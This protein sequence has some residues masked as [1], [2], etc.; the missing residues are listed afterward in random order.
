MDVY[1]YRQVNVSIPRRVHDDVRAQVSKSTTYSKLEGIL[2]VE[3]YSV[4]SRTRS[5]MTGTQIPQSQ[6]NEKRFDGETSI[7]TSQN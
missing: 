6:G 4:R 7:W 2:K 3:A 5:E 1:I